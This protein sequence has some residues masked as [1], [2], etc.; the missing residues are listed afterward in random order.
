MCFSLALGRRV[1]GRRHLLANRQQ[2]AGGAAERKVLPSDSMAGSFRA[3]RGRA[4]G[5]LL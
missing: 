2:P 1:D 5:R 3:L 4:A